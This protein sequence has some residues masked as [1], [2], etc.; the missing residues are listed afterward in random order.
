MDARYDADAGDLVLH[1]RNGA[2]VA[3]PVAQIPELHGQSAAQ[4]AHIEVFP[5]RDGLF[6]PS[7]DVA[8]SAPGL[9]A[10]FFGSAFH[11]KLD[12]AGGSR[13]TARR[14]AGRAQRPADFAR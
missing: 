7:I 2:R 11:A 12:S 9:L 3:L 8:I 5:L 4:L 6:W 13:A 1:L 10:D 14:A